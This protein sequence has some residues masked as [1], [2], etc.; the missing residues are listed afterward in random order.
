MSNTKQE[1]NTR[2]NNSNNYTDNNAKRINK[3]RKKII[4]NE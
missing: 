4:E 3:L 1:R 2:K